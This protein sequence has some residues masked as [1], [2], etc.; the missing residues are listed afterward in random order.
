MRVYIAGPYSAD[1]IAD[2]CENIQRARDACAQLI[3]MG[4]TPFCPHTM[5]AFMDTLYPDLKFGDF[6]RVDIEWLEQC[7]AVLMLD[8]WKHSPGAIIEYNRAITLGKKVFCRL[9]EI[10]EG[11][12]ASQKE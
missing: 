5:T 1:N 3:R 6:I 4:H 9:E 11:Q 2:K 8:G 7:D 12:Y 10:G